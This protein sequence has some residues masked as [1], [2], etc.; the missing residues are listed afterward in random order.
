MLYNLD[1]HTHFKVRTKSPRRYWSKVIS[2]NL[3]GTA[4]TEYNFS[5]PKKAY[6]DLITRKPKDKILIPGMKIKTDG[7]EVLI[8]SESPDIYNY[9]LLYEDNISLNRLIDFCKKKNYLI[10]I[11][12]PFG[13]ISNSATYILGLNKLEKI[14]KEKKI[15]VE[16]YTGTIGYLSYYLFDSFFLRKLRVLLDFLELHK[17]FKVI[18]LSEISEFFT[19]KLDQ[20]SYDIVYKFEAAIKLGKIASYITAG[21]GSTEINSI[22]SGVVTLDLP[23]SLIEE[24]DEL[25]R[26]KLILNRISKKKI[27]TVGPPGN[28]TDKLFQRST[29]RKTKRK[30]YVD[31]MYLT[32]RSV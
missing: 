1:L 10:S 23:K 3:L 2:E 15:G 22:G 28:Y 5:N 6:F 31:L 32:K 26:N 17:M 19:Q 7:G 14:I 21:S 29:A 16:A 27:K 13:L 12:H 18:G 4:I 11:A 25:I 30:A 20:K 24:K 8:F 9:S